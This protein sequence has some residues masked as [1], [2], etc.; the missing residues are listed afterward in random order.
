MNPL[1]T[2]ALLAY[3]NLVLP[4]NKQLC[5][6]LATHGLPRHPTHLERYTYIYALQ[7]Y[8]I[9]LLLTDREDNHNDAMI[10]MN[11]VKQMT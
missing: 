7:S 11:M 2:R 10:L 3:S 4:P 1:Q 6:E 9:Q 5:L 8:S